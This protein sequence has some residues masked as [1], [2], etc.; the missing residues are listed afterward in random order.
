MVQDLFGVTPDPAQA[1]VLEA[2]PKCPRIAMQSCTGS[3]KTATLAWLGW[4]FLLTRPHPIIGATSITADNLKSNLW[5]ELA[6]WYGSS[7]LLQG[8]F[9]LQKTQIISRE[10]PTT[11]KLEARTFARDA[12]ATTVANALRGL[13]AKYVMWLLD[14]TGAYPDAVLPTCEA[15]FSGDPAEAHIVQAGNPTNLGG[16]LYQAATKSRQHWFVVEIT[17]DPEDPNRTP[18]VSIEHARIQIDTYGK[19]N[20]WVLV[21]IFGRFPPSSFNA[22]IGPDE[23]TASFRRSPP[24]YEIGTPAKIIGVD[25]ARFGDDRSVMAR[26]EGILMHPFRIARNIDSTVG[27][28]WVLREVHEFGASAVFVDDTGGFGAGW[29]DQLRSLG[30][31]PIGIHFAGEASNKTRYFNKRTEMYFDFVEWIRSGG[32]LPETPE[33]VSELTQTT[34]TFKGDKLILE[35]KED[36]KAKIGHS[37]DI[38]DA[39]ALTFAYPVVPNV[40]MRRILPQNRRHSYDYDPF[41]SV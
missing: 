25:V 38:S 12:D 14:E 26:R 9:E 15:I 5:S 11:W 29:I 4:N 20:P 30:Q 24:L 36:V 39:A 16:P 17:A 7:A 40:D 22:L 34:Y 33:I 10:F 13:H 37:P 32:A 35:P 41:E 19:D 21:N 2:F 23:I 18:R 8:A 6:R 28:G 31:T 27:A 3:G 1:R